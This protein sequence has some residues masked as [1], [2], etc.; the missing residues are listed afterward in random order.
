MT[1][2]FAVDADND[3]YIGEN[4]DMAVNVDLLAVLQACAHRVKAQFAEMVLQ[5]Q[6]GVPNFQLIWRGAPNLLQYE[7]YV[8]DAI[9]EVDG[10]IEVTQLEAEVVESAV[11]YQATIRT[12]YGTGNING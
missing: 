7:A 8:R 2:V 4:G 3:L 6:Q 11:R 5:T 12:I 9:L 10:V 1:R